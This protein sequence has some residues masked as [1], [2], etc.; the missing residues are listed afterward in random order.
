MSEIVATYDYTD[1]AGRLIYQNCRFD[2]KTFRQRRP[3]GNMDFTW[4]LTGV[5]RTLYRLPQ[6]IDAPKQDFVF[7]VEG[8]KDCD[9]LSA[10]E[11]TATTSG[12]STSWKP[13]F[14]KYFRGRLVCIVPDN[15][16]AGKRFAE[17]V[18][19]SLSGKAT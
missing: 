18:A 19:E 6:L 5:K 4:D 8:E 16:T 2:P 14:A 13:E 3:N 15:D 17:S 1:A 7:I 10:L 11:L 9:A 12:S